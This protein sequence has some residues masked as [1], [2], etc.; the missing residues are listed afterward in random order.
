MPDRVRFIVSGKYCS[1]L[2]FQKKSPPFVLALLQIM[3]VV[4]EAME[5]TLPE[6]IHG[7]GDSEADDNFIKI[8]GKPESPE[9]LS[10]STSELSPII[11]AAALNILGSHAIF[12]RNW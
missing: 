2:I 9:P 5:S 12:G 7:P 6:A 1:T 4:A 10:P 11:V 8:G 3:L